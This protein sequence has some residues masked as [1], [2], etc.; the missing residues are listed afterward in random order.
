MK[1][2]YV[3]PLAEPVESSY[4]ANLI[5]HSENWADAKDNG[6]G[7]NDNSEGGDLPSQPDIWDLWE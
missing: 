4:T 3:K 6:V 1:K 7:T 2:V 5:C